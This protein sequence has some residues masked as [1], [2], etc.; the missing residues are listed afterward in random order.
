MGMG[1]VNPRR[2]MISTPPVCPFRAAA[3]S[4]AIRGVIA[5]QID[6]HLAATT[7]GHRFAQ[8]GSAVVPDRT[9]PSA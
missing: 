8:A 6:A 3:K 4:V 1:F 7:C 9:T 2:P 5:F